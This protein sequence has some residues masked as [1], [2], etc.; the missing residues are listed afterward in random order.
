VDVHGHKWCACARLDSGSCEVIYVHKHSTSL[1][2]LMV[3]S[4]NPTLSG[5]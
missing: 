3:A 5:Q 1:H 2:L 4:A